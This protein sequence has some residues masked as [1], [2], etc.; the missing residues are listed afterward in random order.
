MKSAS[1]A[2]CIPY[3]D[4][5]DYL[6]DYLAL[7]SLKLHREVMMARALRGEQR[8]ES[9]LG[10]FISEQDIASILAELH[11]RMLEDFP[12]GGLLLERINTQTQLIECRL[13]VTQNLLPHQQLAQAFEL[14]DFEIELL[15]MA[16]APE[17]D[18]RFA[19]VY[20]F[21]HDDVA[22]KCLSASLAQ[23]V[24][25]QHDVSGAQLRSAL[26]SNATLMKFQLLALLDDDSQPL[27]SRGLKLDNR[28]VNFLLDVEQ[29]DEEIVAVLQ[30]PWSAKV[31]FDS[32]ECIRSAGQAAQNWLQ[33]PLPLMLEVQASADVDVWLS[34][35]CGQIEMPLMCVDW[36]KLLQLDVARASR[37]LV[38]VIREAHL[39]NRILHLRDV[40]HDQPRLLAVLMSAITPLVCVSSAQRLLLE[41]Y[42]VIAFEKRVPVLSVDNRCACWAS[43]MPAFIHFDNATLS[44]YAQRYSIGV[45]DIHA[46]CRNLEVNSTQSQFSALLNADCRQRVGNKMRDVAQHIDT[47]FSFNDL[48]LS[49]LTMQLLK[50]L[51]EQQSNNSRVFTEWGMADLFHQAQGSAVLF[52]GQSGTGKTM[53]ASVVANELGLDMYRVDLSGVVSKYIGE[54]E[55]NLERIFSTAAQSQVVLFIDEADS[56]FGK[57]SD[58]KDAHDRYANIEVSYLL[59]K[60]EEH[61]GVVIL[62]SNFGHNI[63]DAFFRRFRAV[64][65]FALPKANDR[66]RLWQKLNQT[67]APLAEN[68]DL[69]FLADRFEI[70]GGHIKNCIMSAAFQAAAQNEP[71]NMQ[72]LIRAVSKEYT[73]IGKP[74]SKNAFGDYYSVLRR[75]SVEL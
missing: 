12:E 11:G 60:M 59:Q 71:I 26:H 16:L 69:Q 44:E 23:Q 29:V 37:L 46:L 67:R 75:E 64:V 9:F 24:L 73:K 63:D 3:Q 72:I 27:M 17:I 22:R 10:L 42:A 15:M 1:S 33:T 6:K 65:E 4:T 28:C 25:L 49:P 52:M 34:I 35:Y 2:K 56:L 21:L 8:Q 32:D 48:V 43:A 68:I 54:T 5:Q 30:T 41:Q 61:T 20:G 39:S 70:T 53:A 74:I 51:V 58:V 50:E 38:K 57:R 14:Q 13:A 66:L 19:K 55:K 62:A 47:K 18:N 40:D 31:T 45:R 36:K 7:L